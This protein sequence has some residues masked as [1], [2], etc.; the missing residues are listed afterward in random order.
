[1]H[2]RNKTI[3]THDIWA[4]SFTG[5]NRSLPLSHIYRIY[6][7]DD[8]KC[9][10]MS[11][12]FCSSVDVLSLCSFSSSL[13]ASSVTVT[14]L[15]NTLTF[16]S[17]SFKLSCLPPLS[18]THSIYNGIFGNTATKLGQIWS[19]TGSGWFHKRLEILISAASFQTAIQLHLS[20]CVE[21][22]RTDKKQMKNT[23]FF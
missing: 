15:T 9:Q 18:D 12:L 21:Q 23:I 2:N 16:F 11:S 8:E 22:N 4:W 6:S 20:E 5:L 14:G 7:K 13:P 19:V 10:Q 1:M 17:A 3:T